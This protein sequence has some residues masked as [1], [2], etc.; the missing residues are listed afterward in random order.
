[1][2]R[3]K[4]K[5]WCFRIF[6][7]YSSINELQLEGLRCQIG[8]I[9]FFSCKSEGKKNRKHSLSD[10]ASNPEQCHLL[11]ISYREREVEG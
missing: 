6:N 2:R 5:L 8:I 1:M 11:L 9:K 7:S 10:G 3:G 4:G